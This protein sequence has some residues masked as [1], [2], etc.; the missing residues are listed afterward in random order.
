LKKKYECDSLEIHAFF[1]ALE[2]ISQKIYRPLQKPAKAKEEK[3]DDEEDVI[4]N[5]D[6]LDQ[7]LNEAI[8]YFEQN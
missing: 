1:D 6:C 7:F 3:A 4:S 2:N 8:P 5:Y